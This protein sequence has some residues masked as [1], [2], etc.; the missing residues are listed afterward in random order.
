MNMAFALMWVFYVNIVW[1]NAVWNLVC[2]RP[3]GLLLQLAVEYLFRWP[4]AV[5]GLAMGGDCG[6]RGL[7]C[8][9]VDAVG[10]TE[11]SC[12]YGTDSGWL[13]FKRLRPGHIRS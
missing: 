11:P 8:R 10:C 5:M 3:D 4:G 9:A 6:V 12:S 7:G 1:F 2:S 13:I